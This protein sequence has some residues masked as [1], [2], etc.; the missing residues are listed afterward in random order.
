MAKYVNKAN[1]VLKHKNCKGYAGILGQWVMKMV[2]HNSE[3]I[4]Q[5]EGDD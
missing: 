1:G 4:V 5:S 3:I 2:K